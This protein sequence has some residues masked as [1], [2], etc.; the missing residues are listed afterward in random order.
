MEVLVKVINATHIGMVCRI[1]TDTPPV[2]DPLGVFGVAGF[3]VSVFA[4]GVADAGHGG[5]D[6]IMGTFKPHYDNSITITGLDGSTCHKPILSFQRAAGY[7]TVYDHTVS[8]IEN[9]IS[10]PDGEKFSAFMEKMQTQ[11]LPY[12]C[13]ITD[14]VEP[15][16]CKHECCKLAAW[17]KFAEILGRCDRTPYAAMHNVIYHI[18]AGTWGNCTMT[19]WPVSA[20]PPVW[21]LEIVDGTGKVES[22]YMGKDDDVSSLNGKTIIHAY[23]D[24]GKLAVGVLG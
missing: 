1:S 24:D 13:M 5:G 8:V 17:L 14:R 15:E 2:R 19:A 23:D 21:R 12:W 18:M 9:D 22:M 4:R 6:D 10:I 3:R 20:S 11:I 7:N 16:K